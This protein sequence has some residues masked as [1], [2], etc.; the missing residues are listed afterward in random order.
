MSS[1]RKGSCGTS[2]PA[3]SCRGDSGVDPAKEPPTG[4]TAALLAARIVYAFNWYN[5]GA[6]L[7]LIGHSFA[8]GPV[9]L[10]IILGSFLVGVGIFQLPAGFAALRW[11]ARRVSLA[12]IGVLGTAGLVSG[13]APSWPLLALVRFI[14][15]AGAAFFFS[16]ALSLIASYFPPGR[17]GPIIGLY[18]GAF[19]LGGAAGL[20]FGATLGEVAGWQY[21]LAVG[22]ALM[23]G[24][25]LVC[26]AV[27]PKSEAI[28]PPPK[29]EAIRSA[30]GSVLRSRSIWA[31]SLS[32]TGF[33]GAI[34]IVA[35]YLVAYGHETFPAWPAGLAA[36]LAAL[37]V[38]LSFPGGPLG[39]WLGER[40]PDRRIILAVFGSLTGV[41]VLAIPFLGLVPLAIDLAGLG[42]VDGI[43]F[44]VLYL[45]PTYLSETRGEGLALGV[46]V[47]N[48]IQVA[49]GSGLAVL[50]GVVVA[51]DGFTL[52]WAF[53][54][55]VTLALLPALLLVRPN[56][57]GAD[58]ETRSV[59]A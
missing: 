52:A 57:G 11:G 31:L 15:G 37:V 3:A 56:R 48:S 17:R 27:L 28:T 7:P 50:F 20:F 26:W 39:G 23:V 42:V 58:S 6:V 30:A 14:A 54:G 49:L 10:G 43:V 9:E 19:S 41:M 59:P 25:T 35:Q 21:A 40:G 12:G 2:R 33:W 38:V 5:V 4:P 45:I 44:A 36:G 47:V 18:N 1:P 24:I 22:G 16:P 34:Y 51:A 53:A 29:V 55:L 13:W 46:A 8:A 32:L